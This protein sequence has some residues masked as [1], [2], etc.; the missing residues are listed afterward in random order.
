MSIN[1][2]KTSRRDF[3]EWKCRVIRPNYLSF[4]GIT[5]Q[6]VSRNN[7]AD[8]VRAELEKLLILF[9]VPGFLKKRLFSCFE[10]TF[11]CNLRVGRVSPN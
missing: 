8:Q 10:Q 5:H 7:I 2:I 11:C 3:G 4:L 1:R 6:L 9:A